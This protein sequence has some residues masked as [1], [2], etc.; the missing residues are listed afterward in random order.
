MPGARFC[1]PAP[2]SIEC[3][4]RSLT[5]RVAHRE[6]VEVLQRGFHSF[7]R[8]VRLGARGQRR[9]PLQHRP[10]PRKR[11]RL[12]RSRLPPFCAVLVVKDGA[13]WRGPRTFPLAMHGNPRGPQTTGAAVLKTSCPAFNYRTEL[14]RTQ[15]PYFGAGSA[16]DGG[17][18]MSYGKS[19][20]S[21]LVDAG[22]PSVRARRA[23]G[24][25]IS[26]D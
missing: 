9:L 23:I 1:D 22:S 2:G 20:T 14:H 24:I 21:Q 8:Q 16:I 17:D 6:A 26:S 11:I 5:C 4:A 15:C 12:L 7:I 10:E 25:A 13:R 18:I 19:H 3:S